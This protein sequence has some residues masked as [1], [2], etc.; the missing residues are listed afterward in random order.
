MSVRNEL[1]EKIQDVLDILDDLEDRFITWDEAFEKIGRMAKEE[2][3]T[4]EDGTKED[5]LV[6]EEAGF[7]AEIHYDGEVYVFKDG[8][9]VYYR[10]PVW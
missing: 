8:K 2:I 9:E 6:V 10:W 3:K 1:P 4:Y 7:R 5:I